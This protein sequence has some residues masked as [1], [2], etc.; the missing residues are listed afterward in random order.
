MQLKY[1]PVEKLKKEIIEILGKHLNLFQYK[2]FFFGS[3]VSSGGND[4]SDIDLGIEGEKPIPPK[5][6]FEIEDEIENLPT[7]YK[8]ELVDFRHVHSQFREVA[9]KNIELII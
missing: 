1:Y 9:L 6:K 8:I 5:I 3:R 4:R 2:V 7:L